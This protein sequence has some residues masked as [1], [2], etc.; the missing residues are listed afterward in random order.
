[1]W[2]HGWFEGAGESFRSFWNLVLLGDFGGE[3]GARR[4]NPHRSSHNN[5]ATQ[6]SDGF[7]F[8]IDRG[9]NYFFR[10]LGQFLRRQ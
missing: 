3:Y 5:L 1:M 2:R 8:N 6:R 10:K 9:R 4:K 7:R